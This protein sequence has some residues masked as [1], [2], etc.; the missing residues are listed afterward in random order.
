M[1]EKIEDV[2]VREFITTWSDLIKK[3]ESTPIEASKMNKLIELYGNQAES[4]IKLY[5]NYE[6]DPD[7]VLKTHCD[8]YVTLFSKLATASSISTSNWKH[9]NPGLMNLIAPNIKLPDTIAL[10]KI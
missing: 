8:I 3:I 10:T 4:L 1:S 5:C 2:A 7:K 9:V 6:K